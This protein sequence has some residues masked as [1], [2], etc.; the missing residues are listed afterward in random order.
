[1]ALISTFHGKIEVGNSLPVSEL[2][3]YLQSL[4]KF[5]EFHRQIPWG[6]EIKFLVCTG[7]EGQAGM[8]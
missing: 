7:A 8:P 3:L 6:M 5:L 4:S 2:D 1:M